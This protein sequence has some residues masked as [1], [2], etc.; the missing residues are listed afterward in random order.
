MIDALLADI[1]KGFQLRKTARGRGEAEGSS[2][3]ASKDPLRV[4]EPGEPLPAASVWLPLL[5]SCDL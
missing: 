5:Q 2:K 3:V 4:P 1:R